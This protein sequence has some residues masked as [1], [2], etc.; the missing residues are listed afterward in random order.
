MKKLM[1]AAA[2]VA[3][4]GGAFA[5]P[6][7][8]DYRANVRHMYLKVVHNVNA[9]DAAGNAKLMD[10][11][12]KVIRSSSLKGYLVMDDDGATSNKVTG[13]LCL[14]DTDG[15][16]SFD[17]GRNR[18]FLVVKD[19][20]L[21][22]GEEVYENVRRPKILPAILDAKWIDQAITKKDMPLTGLAEG[23][24]FCGGDSIACTRTILDEIAGVVTDRQKAPQLPG[25][26]PFEAPDDPD[27]AEYTPGKAG[28]TAYADYLWTSIYLFGQ[29]NGPNWYFDYVQRGVDEDNKPIM[30]QAGPF[31]YFELAWDGQLPKGLQI[32]FKPEHPYFHDTWMNGA[33]FGTYIKP[34]T[35]TKA[36][37]CGRGKATKHY[38]ILLNTLSGQVKGGLFLC[39]EN[40]IRAYVSNYAFFDGDNVRWENQFV[41]KRILP[42]VTFSY[43][44]YQ[45][46]MWQDGSVEQEVT[47]VITGNWAIRYN[48]SFLLTPADGGHYVAV[49][50]DEKNY[51]LP[52]DEDGKVQTAGEWATTYSQD[53]AG[54]IKSAMLVL[55]PTAVF[56]DTTEI[57]DITI[58]RQQ[59]IEDGTDTLPLVTPKFCKYYGLAN[60][61]VTE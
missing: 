61:K 2:G 3:M 20:T 53:L 4:V 59:A 40:A 50:K 30:V 9:T 45:N 21:Q 32:G 24:L 11:Y 8:Y 36:A 43:D 22:A 55:D 39:T 23:Y 58:E 6:L 35:T 19:L 48:A 42:A 34:K 46:D 25:T 33:G 28:M 31:D 29:Y 17:F 49:T 60:F 27:E 16:V 26:A 54:A 7:V 51:M 15:T 18:G 56:A 10:I 13:G 44:Y 52:K 14:P 41:T 5:E 1:I 38:D 47:D 57:C 12:A 37:C